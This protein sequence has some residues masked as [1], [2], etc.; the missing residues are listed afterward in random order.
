MW[1]CVC[2]HAEYYVYILIVVHVVM[3]VDR[4][5]N[6]VVSM[7]YHIITLPCIFPHR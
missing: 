2:V 7:D 3:Y 6:D 4:W 5:H 1:V